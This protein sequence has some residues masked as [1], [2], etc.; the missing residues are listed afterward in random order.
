[1]VIVA[2]WLGRKLVFRR[3]TRG[4]SLEVGHESGGKPDPGITV[5]SKAELRN[6]KAGD[7]TGI[8]ASAPGAAAGAE[9]IDVLR[10]AKV[11]NARLGD[12]SG[13]KIGGD[14]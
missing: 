3:D 2:L 4:T 6:V 1:V 12:I 8:K 13:M 10:E 7:V 9:R 5:G 14:P 11:E